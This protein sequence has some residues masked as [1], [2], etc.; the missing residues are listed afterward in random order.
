M[1]K[2]QIEE[3]LAP[4]KTSYEKGDVEHYVCKGGHWLRVDILDRG[5]APLLVKCPKCPRMMATL[6]KSLQGVPLEVRHASATHEFYRPESTRYLGRA[7]RDEVHK[8]Q[9]LFR[10][11][12]KR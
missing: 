10:E 7:D 9:L 1:T 8:G 2:A 3:A 12:G 4:Q 6:F 5:E 11:K